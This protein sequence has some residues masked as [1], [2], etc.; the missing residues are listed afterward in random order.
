MLTA[1]GDEKCER[2][3]KKPVGEAERLACD[4]THRNERG[5]DQAQGSAALRL[6]LGESVA[7]QNQ[8]AG[9]PEPASPR[10][11]RAPAA[12]PLPL[13][14]RGR[15]P[16]ARASPRRHGARRCS[17]APE[18][19]SGRPTARLL[20]SRAGAAVLGSSPRSNS[21]MGW[22]RARW[23]SDVLRV[24]RAQDRLRHA[25][26][27]AP[28]AHLGQ[29]NF[30]THS[31]VHGGIIPRFPRIPLSTKPELAVPQNVGL[32]PCR[33]D[34][35]PRVRTQSADAPAERRTLLGASEGTIRRRR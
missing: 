16:P 24:E 1:P 15:R 6:G 21:A 29:Q 7:A 8:P 32:K 14:Q 20:S 5:S 30:Q 18:T 31:L 19:P 17:C 22:S 11:S 9:P 2:P 12:R 25:A 23:A 10:E 26:P 34:L 3:G 13:H 33:G 27:L 28:K 4:A 35:P